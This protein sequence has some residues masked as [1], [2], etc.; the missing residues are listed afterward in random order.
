MLQHE[1]NFFRSNQL[2]SDNQIT[3]IFTVF[4][5]NDNNELTLTEIFYRFFNGI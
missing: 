3:F 5:I 1:I 2:C 4:V